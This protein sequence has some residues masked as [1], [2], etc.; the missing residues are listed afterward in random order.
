MT[1]D[2]KD[3]TIVGVIPANFRL[4]IPGFREAQ[5]YVPIGSRPIPTCFSAGPGWG[6]MGLAGS[7]L[8]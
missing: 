1:L 4:T 3:Y 8:A 5:V 7:S 2:A 6:S